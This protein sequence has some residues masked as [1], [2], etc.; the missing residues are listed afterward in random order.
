MLKGIF[1]NKNGELTKPEDISFSLKCDNCG[2]HAKMYHSH[3]Y[4]RVDK[5][6]TRTILTLKCECGNHFEIT[7]Y[8]KEL[9]KGRL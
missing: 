7:V 9:Y 8:D 6:P 1:V 4:N 2:K 3:E 5:Y